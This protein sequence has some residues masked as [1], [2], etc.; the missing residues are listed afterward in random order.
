MKE[1]EKKSSQTNRKFLFKERNPNLMGPG[2]T[3]IK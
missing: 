3:S 1:L 2:R